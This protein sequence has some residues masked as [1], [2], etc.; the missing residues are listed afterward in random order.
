MTTKVSSSPSP[1]YLAGYERLRNLD[2]ASMLFLLR[3]E[4]NNWHSYADI[5]QALHL[6]A[7]PNSLAKPGAPYWKV[8][9]KWNESPE[10]QAG[11]GKAVQNTGA[12]SEVFT[13]DLSSPDALSSVYLQEAIRQGFSSSFVK[14]WVSFYPELTTDEVVESLRVSK[15][16]YQRLLSAE[17]VSLSAQQS[18][19]LLVTEHVFQRAAAVLGSREEASAWLR[20]PALAFDNKKPMELLST[21][22]GAQIVLDQLMRIE[23]GVLA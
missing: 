6:T 10:A 21:S 9:F 11:L 17:P 13:I 20:R 16:T 23:Y 14:H 5:P 4:P 22:T 8:F 19:G 15:R 7:Q 1:V 3:A 2:L 18:E 12:S